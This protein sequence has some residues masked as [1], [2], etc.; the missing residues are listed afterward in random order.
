MPLRSD[1]SAVRA[2]DVLI[3]DKA[4]A[5]I[6]DTLSLPQIRTDDDVALV[7]WYS[8]KDVNSSKGRS[9][10]HSSKT[11]GGWFDDR[12]TT[13]TAMSTQHNS[14]YSNEDGIDIVHRGVSSK[15]SDLL[16]MLHPDAS[17]TINDKEHVS[18]SPT[19]AD[20]LSTQEN[21]HYSSYSSN[22]WLHD[23]HHDHH[24]NDQ[25]NYISSITGQSSFD[26]SAISSTDTALNEIGAMGVQMIFDDTSPVGFLSEHPGITNHQG[27]YLLKLF[28][29]NHYLHKVTALMNNTTPVLHDKSHQQVATSFKE[30]FFDFQKESSPVYHGRYRQGSRITRS[31]G[32]RYGPRGCIALSDI[33]MATFAHDKHVR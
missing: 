13:S 9:G 16:S 27:S 28:A 19:D 1:F 2:L 29:S 6:I 23:H 20:N 14:D 22:Y 31:I 5:D 24:H 4:A 30:S 25:H 12:T 17:T 18:T 11:K 32:D 10:L 33:T 8:S 26:A 21:N 15:R 3:D 7:G